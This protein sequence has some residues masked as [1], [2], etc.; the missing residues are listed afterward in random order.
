M[1]TTEGFDFRWIAKKYLPKRM[2]DLLRS[3][4]PESIYYPGYGRTTLS[5]KKLEQLL[6]LLKECL[7]KNLDG[8]LIECGVFRGGSL[9]QIG[10]MAQRMT[11]T[12]S[13]F[14]LDTFEGHPFD[15][16]EDVPSDQQLVHHKGLFA[17]NSYERVAQTL[18]QNGIGN[19]VLLKGRIEG[20]I[21][22]LADRKFCFAHLDLDLY[23]S[24]RQALSFIV[25]RLV[26]GGVIVFDD[27][28]SFDAPGVEKAVSEI[29]P[30]AE[31]ELSAIDPREGN[32]AYWTNT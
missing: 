16:P 22:A 13:L 11:P 27:Y 30:R 3:V 9:V 1:G 26:R 6:R 15:G 5:G 21:G 25:P 32:Q 4:L 2:T 29:L 20:T 24:T 19:A 23:E 17:G 12:K 7:S 8:D 28:G 18:E 10:R 14:G 31:I